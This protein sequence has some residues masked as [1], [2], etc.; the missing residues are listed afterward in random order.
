MGRNIAGTQGLRLARPSTR[1]VTGSIQ[2]IVSLGI[3]KKVRKAMLSSPSTSLY[4][5]PGRS[6][7]SRTPQALES[8][9]KS[10]A[11]VLFTQTIND[12]KSDV[13]SA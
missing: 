13:N 2:L 8:S 1:G 4:R 5:Q 3:Y 12:W 6:S 7:V 9:L 11:V 10:P